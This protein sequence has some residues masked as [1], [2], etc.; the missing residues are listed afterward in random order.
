MFTLYQNVLHRRKKG[1]KPGKSGLKL[2]RKCLTELTC[3]PSVIS[4]A[5]RALSYNASGTLVCGSTGVFRQ[6]VTS[7][8]ARWERSIFFI[9]SIRNKKV[10]SPFCLPFGQGIPPSQVS[11]ATASREEANG[12][13][14][15]PRPLPTEVHCSCGAW[16]LPSALEQQQRGVW[17]RTH[18]GE[19]QSSKSD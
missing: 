9:N 14:P 16:A 17:D 11:L 4:G 1:G 19:D 12:P 3:S 10:T 13:I 15:I 8:L 5:A 7:T 18:R 6:D 2:H